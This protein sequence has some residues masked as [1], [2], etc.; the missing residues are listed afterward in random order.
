MAQNSYTASTQKMDHIEAHY[1]RNSTYSFRHSDQDR[2]NPPRAV[3]SEIILA[4]NLST[5]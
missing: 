5:V 3:I 2:R 4:L 1:L